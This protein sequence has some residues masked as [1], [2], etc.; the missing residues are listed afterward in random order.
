MRFS[1]CVLEF[2]FHVRFPDISTLSC[3]PGSFSSQYL[4]LAGNDEHWRNFVCNV[5]SSF[6][7][8]E[9]K[10]GLIIKDQC[11][12]LANQLLKSVHLNDFSELI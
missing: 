12:L 10:I 1:V 9:I 4:S 5:I 11:G 2:V 3:L 6:Y 7:L 8:Q